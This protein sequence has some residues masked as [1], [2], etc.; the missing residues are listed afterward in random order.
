[1]ELGPSD[2]RLRQGVELSPILANSFGVSVLNRKEEE[3]NEQYGSF[4]GSAK[5]FNFLI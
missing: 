5:V 3:N 1:M 2:T 4:N